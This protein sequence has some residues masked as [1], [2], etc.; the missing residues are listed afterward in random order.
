MNLRVSA[1]VVLTAFVFPWAAFA[2]DNLCD[3]Y[4]RLES[5]P[6][7]EQQA[8][9]NEVVKASKIG[10]NSQQLCAAGNLYNRLGK[11]IYD[12]LQPGT[13]TYESMKAAAFMNLGCVWIA[14]LLIKGYVDGMKKE[15]PN[16][17]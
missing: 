12:E 15:C 6:R 8:F 11:S 1:L 3:V 2:V 9:Y 16:V 5:V 13:E 7:K 17:Y 4:N 10:S 14:P